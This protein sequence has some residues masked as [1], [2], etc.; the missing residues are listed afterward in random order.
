MRLFCGAGRA[1]PGE[2]K[3]TAVGAAMRATPPLVVILYPDSGI[4]ARRQSLWLAL[5]R[6]SEV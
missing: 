5:S 4:R 3:K 2:H 1:A 6:L